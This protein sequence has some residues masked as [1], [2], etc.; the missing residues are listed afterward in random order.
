MFFRVVS[1]RSWL[2]AAS[3]ARMSRAPPLAQRSSGCR[4]RAMPG[5][6]RT[7]KAACDERARLSSGTGT[8][9]GWPYGRPCPSGTLRKR[10]PPA[11]RA[12]R[13]PASAGDGFRASNSARRRP[14]RWQPASGGPRSPCAASAARGG[15]GPSAAAMR[16]GTPRCWW[17]D[18]G[19]ASA[20]PTFRKVGNA[21]SGGLH[22]QARARAT[23]SAAAHA[24]REVLAS[25][26][27]FGGGPGSARTSR[28]STCFGRPWSGLGIAT[29]EKRP[30]GPFDEAE[31]A[32]EP[33]QRQEGS[34][35]PRRRTAPREEESSGGRNPKSGSGMKYFAGR[36]GADQGVERLREP[37]DA[38]GR[39]RQ[40]RPLGCCRVREY[41]EGAKN[42][43][44]GA[45]AT[46]R[47][48]EGHE[49]AA[50][51]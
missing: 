3:V 8:G 43:M 50:A 28:G 19:S 13:R 17:P 31:T 37:E 18:A 20:P 30:S 48:R 1:G 47:T 29:S 5:S 25:D 46:C 2:R 40:T 24:N 42:L 35:R 49:G 32:T 38:S 14:L 7:A 4:A 39:A 34:R 33:V 21:R 16:F 27:R 51:A 15:S 22:R 36:H 6:A 11:E 12:A 41:A 10:T 44:G 26:S 23:A 45:V 9:F